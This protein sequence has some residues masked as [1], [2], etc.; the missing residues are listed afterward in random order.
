M[1]L[2]GKKIEILDL[3]KQ[4]FEFSSSGFL[5]KLI[6][7]RIHDLPPRGEIDSWEPPFLFTIKMMNGM[8]FQDEI[9]VYYGDLEQ[10]LTHLETM[11]ISRFFSQG[12][13]KIIIENIQKT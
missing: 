2:F 11:L 7:T 3:R 9:R 10:I 4:E 6:V 12:L 13:T 5:F 8:V 1:K